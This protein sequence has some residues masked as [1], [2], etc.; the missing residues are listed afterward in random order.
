MLIK[1]EGGPDGA[2]SHVLHRVNVKLVKA[3][4]CTNKQ[5]L[6]S[7]KEFMRERSAAIIAKFWR[8]YGWTANTQNL[9]DAFRTVKLTE[10]DARAMGFDVLVKHLRKKVVLRVAL[11]FMRRI[12]YSAAKLLKISYGDKIFNIRVFLCTFMIAFYEHCVFEYV[13]TKEQCVID[14]THRL[15]QNVFNIAELLAQGTA[16]RDIPRAVTEALPGLLTGFENAFNAWKTPDKAV[17]VARIEH[18]TRMLMKHF[19]IIDP[20]EPLDAHRRAEFRAQICRLRDQLR[21]INGPNACRVFDEHILGCLI[22]ETWD[23]QNPVDWPLW[24]NYHMEEVFGAAFP[25]YWEAEGL[26]ANQRFIEEFDMRFPQFWEVW[27][28]NTMSPVLA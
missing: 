22:Y 5:F 19:R 20:Y 24:A 27:A 8:R 10:R 14:W 3:L 21:Q 9:A 11:Q 1:L 6:T 26:A 23:A 4:A 12:M 17:L 25:H 18:A 2:L 28:T 13:G 15:I 16:F 7:M